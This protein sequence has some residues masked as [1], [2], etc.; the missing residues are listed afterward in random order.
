VTVT[1]QEMSPLRKLSGAVTVMRGPITNETFGPCGA[2]RPHGR[3]GGPTPP[4]APTG[5]GRDPEL[6][7]EPAPGQRRSV[8]RR[9]CSA[10]SHCS[11]FRPWDV[12]SSWLFGRGERQMLY[13]LSAVTSYG[14]TDL[15]LAPHLRMMGALETL[16][17]WILF[18]LTAAF[19]FTVMQKAWP[20]TYERQNR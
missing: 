13:S 12:P 15:H 20:H 9:R 5:P 6:Q 14:H 7:A 19:L 10:L 2:A 1:S 11:S 4:N 16:N 3:G 17:G 18:G 8:H